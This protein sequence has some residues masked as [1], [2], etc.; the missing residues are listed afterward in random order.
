M[1]HQKDTKPGKNYP[2]RTVVSTKWLPPY[3]TLKDLVKTIQPTFNKNK[4]S[5]KFICEKSKRMEYIDQSSEIQSLL[6]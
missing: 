1:S 5:F 4:M 3:D 2:M 6:M